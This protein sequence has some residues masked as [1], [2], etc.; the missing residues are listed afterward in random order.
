MSN[1]IQSSIPDWR[2]KTHWIKLLKNHAMIMEPMHP[3]QYQDN[4]VYFTFS[5]T[6][7][8]NPYRT[9]I[10]TMT[11]GEIQKLCR[12][13]GPSSGEGIVGGLITGGET[14]T[15]LMKFS[16]CLDR[17]LEL[18]FWYHTSVSKFTN[19]KKHIMNISDSFRLKPTCLRYFDEYYD[20]DAS[21]TILLTAL[22]NDRRGGSTSS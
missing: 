7:I 5:W 13:T 1:S 6:V 20:G 18:M 10:T 21:A 17:P 8:S 19:L 15:K 4:K 11:Q 9:S 3:V 16:E 22:Y 14:N 12:A 2:A